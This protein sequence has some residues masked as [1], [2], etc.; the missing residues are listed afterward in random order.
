M[1]VVNIAFKSQKPFPSSLQQIPLYLIYRPIFIYNVIGISYE[2]L[3][4]VYTYINV[5]L[6]HEYLIFTENELSF[7]LSC[8]GSLC[9]YFI[10]ISIA[11]RHSDLARLRKSRHED[12]QI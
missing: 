10:D 3:Y 5:N 7:E 8:K 11:S 6:W 1:H 9:N 4:Y 12:R 2:Y